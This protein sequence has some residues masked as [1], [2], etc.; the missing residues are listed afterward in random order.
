MKIRFAVPVCL[1]PEVFPGV[2]NPGPMMEQYRVQ[3]AKLFYYVLSTNL[4]I[5]D[6]MC[7]CQS[8]TGNVIIVFKH[9]DYLKVLAVE[10]W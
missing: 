10:F 4:K 5:G 8:D 3:Y 9:S 7:Q 6:Y 2:D 1:T